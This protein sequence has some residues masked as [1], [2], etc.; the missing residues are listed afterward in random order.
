MIH[1]ELRE[2]PIEHCNKSCKNVCQMNCRPHWEVYHRP[3]F[4][5][6]NDETISFQ[7]QYEHEHD[8]GSG[9]ASNP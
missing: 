8:K 5:Y 2:G 7:C 1:I 4:A 6:G 3:I 9:E